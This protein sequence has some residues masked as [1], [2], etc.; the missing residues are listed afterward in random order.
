MTGWECEHYVN[1]HYILHPLRNVQSQSYAT[2]FT[3]QQEN[4]RHDT[5]SADSAV[6]TASRCDLMHSHCSVDS[7]SNMAYPVNNGHSVVEAEH[8]EEGT[9]EGDTGQQNVSDPL[10]A[11]HLSV[12]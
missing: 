10:G 3:K 6:I 4:Q 7:H 8:E 12:V 1:V 5:S 11:L 9:A 2:K